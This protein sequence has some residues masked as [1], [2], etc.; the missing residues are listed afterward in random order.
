MNAVNHRPGWEV[1]HVPFCPLEFSKMGHF[2]SNKAFTVCQIPK[3][4]GTIKNQ[5]WRTPTTRSIRKPTITSQIS[6]TPTTTPQKASEKVAVWCIVAFW[7]RLVSEWMQGGAFLCSWLVF[8]VNSGARLSCLWLSGLDFNWFVCVCVD[9]RAAAR[10]PDSSVW[11][12]TEFIGNM[13]GT[14]WFITIRQQQFCRTFRNSNEKGHGAIILDLAWNWSNTS[15]S[16]T[17][18]TIFESANG[19]IKLEVA[20]K[21]KDDT[22]NRSRKKGR[23]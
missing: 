18:I 19:W 23:R 6:K 8:L 3:K 12:G 4:R 21:R 1:R 16:I 14:G 9:L 15:Y 17:R 2:N 13:K 5:M 20:K 10:N 22:L 11:N 7:S